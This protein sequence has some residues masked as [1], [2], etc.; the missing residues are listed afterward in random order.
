MRAAVRD[1]VAI[2]LAL[3]LAAL[4]V[5]EVVFVPRDHIAF[6]WHAV[7][8]YA[9]LIGFGASILIVLI[10]KQLGTWLLQRPVRDDD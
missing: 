6:H 9:A 8:G 1:R 4:V 10:S 2:G 7:P 3:A 5:I